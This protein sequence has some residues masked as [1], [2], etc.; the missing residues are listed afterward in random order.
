M[1][2]QDFDFKTQTGK[3]VDLLELEDDAPDMPLKTF[4]ISIKQ[5]DKLKKE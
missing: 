3:H 5:F 2:S 4:K 1:C